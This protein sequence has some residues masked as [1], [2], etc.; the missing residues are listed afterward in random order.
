[1]VVPQE[2]TLSPLIVTLVRQD[3]LVG[4]NDG[5]AA[6][7]KLEDCK[8]TQC[9]PKGRAGQ[10]ELLFPYHKHIFKNKNLRGL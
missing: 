5:Y 8:R 7:T 4:T 9:T 3:M 2:C 6:F 10:K 1:M